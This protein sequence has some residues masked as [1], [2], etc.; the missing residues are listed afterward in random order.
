[1]EQ[2]ESV[3]EIKR[4]HWWQTA[5]GIMLSAALLLAAAAALLFVL[6]RVGVI[7]AREA[8][9]AIPE[10]SAV[11]PQGEVAGT[12]ADAGDARSLVAGSGIAEQ[13]TKVIFAWPR[14]VT[15]GKQNN[16]TYTLRYPSIEPR[17]AESVRLVLMVRLNNQQAYQ[18][19]FW[20]ASFRLVT[21][22]EVIPA[23]GGLN[24]VVDARSFSAE[25]R[26]VF[27]VPNRATV[28]AL[29]ITYL[30]ESTDLPLR[31]Q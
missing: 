7:G 17:N 2:G 26:V 9:R 22:N 20:D 15:L 6:H 21:E 31:L 11:R 3:S 19:N 12:S 25:Q 24:V 30:D 18:A 23:S 5:P 13:P 16:V 27:N 1:V 8:A 10:A 28:R 29:R 4:V 14:D